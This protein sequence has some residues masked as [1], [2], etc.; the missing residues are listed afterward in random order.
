MI[1]T[2]RQQLN[3]YRDSVLALQ[4]K[5]KTM[6]PEQCSTL[7]NEL[8]QSGIWSDFTVTS[9]LDGRWDIRVVS[10][11]S[12]RSD[13]FSGDCFYVALLKFNK[14]AMKDELAALDKAIEKMRQA[15][16][17]AEGKDLV[18][19]EVCK[20]QAAYL[21]SGDFELGGLA[22]LKDVERYECADCGGIFF[23][24]DQQCA[25]H[26]KMKDV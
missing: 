23:T 11:L 25:L 22:T 16:A 4:A 13:F 9:Y 10:S 26:E 19:C 15:E 17:A 5:I 12:R 7:L 8:R 21:V 20:R 2:R 14:R 24:V 1:S 3:Q 6:S 18:T